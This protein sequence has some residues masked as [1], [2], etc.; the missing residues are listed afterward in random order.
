M[1]AAA[2]ADTATADDDDDDDDASTISSYQQLISLFLND[3][4]TINEP[5]ISS[6]RSFL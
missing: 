3:Y 6:Q 4:Q 1:T 5:L 2:A